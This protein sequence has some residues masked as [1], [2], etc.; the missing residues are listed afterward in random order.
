MAF[1]DLDPVTRIEAILNGDDIDPVTRREYFLQKAATEVPKPS[2]AADAGKVPTVNSDGDG[3]V[4]AEIPKELPAYAA[5]DKGKVLTIGYGVTPGSVVPKWEAVGDSSLP[6]LSVR[7]SITGGALTFGSIRHGKT[8]ADYQDTDNISDLITL[9]GGYLGVNQISVT[10]NDQTITN[11]API[12]F[13]ADTFTEIGETISGFGVSV[14]VVAE[15]ITQDV[16][17]AVKV[18]V[19]LDGVTSLDQITSATFDGCSLYSY[20]DEFLVLFYS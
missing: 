6:A 9:A 10:I 16:N 20:S 2:A 5:A 15:E 19:E 11:T 12:L 3:Y 7:K 4:L 8:D 1:T 13:N 14:R 18:I 17:Y